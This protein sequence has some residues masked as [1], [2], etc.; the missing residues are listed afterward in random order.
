MAAIRAF[1]AIELSEATRDAAAGIVRLLRARPGGE[2]VRWVRAESLHV[3]LRFLG[4]IDPASVPVLAH[5]VSRETAVLKPFALRVGALAAFPTPRRPRVVALS[6]EP[7]DALAELGAAIE[8]GVV[9]AGFAPESRPFRA[10][11][12]LGRLRGG[13]FP[14]AHDLPAPPPAP[15]LVREVALFQSRLGPGGSHYTP[16]ERMTLG[17]EESP[18]TQA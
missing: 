15:T 8:R 5:Q 6:I 13:R 14:D 16:L 4:D 3:T 18:R 17:G 11:L 2:R 1:V 10:H 7:G 9:A 12:T